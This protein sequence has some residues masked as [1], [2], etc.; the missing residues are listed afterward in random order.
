MSRNLR[1][2]NKKIKQN[3]NN[4]AFSLSELEAL[5]IG[6]KKLGARLRASRT[7]K[8]SHSY[9]PATVILMYKDAL[10]FLPKLLPFQFPK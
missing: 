3:W 8:A 1:K 5:N 9:E 10:I 2:K 6:A 7:Q 4:R